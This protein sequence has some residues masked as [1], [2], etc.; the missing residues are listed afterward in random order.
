MRPQPQ[1]LLGIAI[2][3]V[4]IGILLLFVPVLQPI[5]I[6]LL[7]GGIA[8]FALFLYLDWDNYETYVEQRRRGEK[9]RNARYNRKTERTMRYLEAFVRERMDRAS[10]E[11]DPED[12]WED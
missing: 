2:I 10:R 5:G 9:F 4:P 12:E 6:L 3:S 11:I 8:A 1:M 7:L